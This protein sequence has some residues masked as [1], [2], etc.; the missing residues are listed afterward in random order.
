MLSSI[1]DGAKQTYQRLT[2]TIRPAV[3]EQEPLRQEQERPPVLHIAE[4]TEPTPAHN[5]SAPLVHRL[6]HK[7]E[8]TLLERRN[9]AASVHRR[10]HRLPQELHSLV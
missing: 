7:P 1:V 5:K 2:V 6:A 9:L 4:G 10:E 3:Q 8:H